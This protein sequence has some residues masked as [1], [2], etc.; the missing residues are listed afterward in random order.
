MVAA[1]LPHHITQRGTNRQKVFYSVR[2]R[3]VYLDLL[4]ASAA[5]TGVRILA[6]CLMLNH[7][8]IIAIPG[9]EG[10]L[11]VCLRRAHGRYAQYLNA[12]RGCSGHL[13]QNR[14]FSC[15][16]DRGHLWRALR[17]VECNPVRARLVARPD[18]YKWSSAGD[19][20][21]GCDTRHMLDMAF[22]QESGGAEFWRQLI[23]SP[24]DEREIGE[25]RGA[26]YA[27]R[28]LGPVEFVERMGRRSADEK[29]VSAKIGQS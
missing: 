20:I 17:Y 3:G 10:A 21:S 22:W 12:R 16:L 26:T 8:H 27:G 9:T 29:A 1:G 5:Q 11:A 14:F 15:V 13:W 2:D 6:Y 18:D 24:E 23:D 25:L 7:I 28:P 4:R 19:H